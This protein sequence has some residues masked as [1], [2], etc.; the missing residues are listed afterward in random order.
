MSQPA[1]AWLRD[2]RK[3]AYVALG[4]LAIVVIG[5][6]WPFAISR[7]ARHLSAYGDGAEDISRFRNELAATGA[8]IQAIGGTPRILADVETPASTLLVVIGTE[9]RYDAGEARAVIE[10]VRAGGSVILA[11]ETGFGSDVASAAG[12]AFSSQRV[13]DT[14]NYRGDE[15]LAVARSSLGGTEYRV[16]F[17]Q[18]SSLLMLSSAQ[19]YQVIASSSEPKFP[20]GSFLDANANGE[21]DI[22][23]QP[24]PFPFIIK[25]K[26]ADER[27]GTIILISDTGPF[28]NAQLGLADYDNARFLRALVS[29]T[30]PADGVIIIDESRHAPSALT[31]A[32]ENSV[33]TL[34]RV[35]MG[36]VAPFI[37]LGVLLA[38][39]IA[40]WRLTR[41]TDDWSHH[42][43][44]ISEHLAVP[45]N[46]RPDATRLQ[47]MARRHI[48]EKFNMPMEQ[49]S[50]MTTD[51][52][53]EVVG[54]RPLSESASGTFKGDPSPMF[55]LFSNS[56]V[57]TP[58]ESQS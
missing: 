51:E 14:Q 24:G 6:A 55:R 49:V 28:M 27:S 25:T 4:V 34:G 52:L 39:S 42:K 44:D 48:S 33:R 1:T 56:S 37:L 46:V 9:R 2:P 47:R 13:L 18:P 41:P 22:A 10:F 20:D 31:A 57:I 26:L 8:R 45:E 35:A 54:D 29:A 38:G 32:W 11:D 53:L 30:V 40:A 5:L 36:D 15:T 3:R 50:A 21:I 43:F 23:D 7:D 19:P 12:F 17:N 16:V 58:Q